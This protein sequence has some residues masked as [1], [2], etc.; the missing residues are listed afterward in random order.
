MTKDYYKILGVS[1][2]ATADEIKKAYRKLA[3]KYHP[4]KTKGDKEAEEKFKEANEAYQVLSDPAKRGNYDRFGSSGGFNGAAGPGGWGAGGFNNAGGFNVGFDFGEDL[5]DIFE[6]FFGGGMAGG[7]RSSRRQKVNLDGK[8]IRVGVNVNFLDAVFGKDIDMKINNL[9]RCESC[10]GSGA[11]NQKTVKC[12]KCQ[13]TGI[14]EVVQQT[15]LGS[16]RQRAICDECDG[17]GEKPEKKCQQCDGKGRV[18]KEVIVKVT[19]PAG[20]DNGTVLRL[21]EMGEAG[22]RG[23]RNGDLL[24]E[25][26]VASDSNFV[27]EG[28]DVYTELL[29]SFPQVA[30]GD[31]VKVKTLDGE[32]ELRVPAGTQYGKVFRLKGIGVPYLG[33]ENRR[34]D[35]LV[36]VKVEVPTSL[37]TKQ[38][39]QLRQYANARNESFNEEGAFDKMKR[40]LGL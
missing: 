29:L 3:H 12:S 14:I 26:R 22:R 19:V 39:E 27:R 30:L 15:I 13:G 6:T 17:A 7:G 20:A 21:R 37:T 4:D 8:D 40:K 32:Y 34:G 18:K 9:V 28:N 1:K 11:E 10:R 24:V 31:L 2:E 25:L 5:G 16:F 35:H 38:K 36:K 23:G 33:N